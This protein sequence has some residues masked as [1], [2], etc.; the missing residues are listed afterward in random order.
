[1]A[2]GQNVPDM[3]ALQ[4]GLLHVMLNSHEAKWYIC[5]HARTRLLQTGCITRHMAKLQGGRSQDLFLPEPEAAQVYKLLGSCIGYEA[6][7][8]RSPQKLANR[9]AYWHIC[10]I[11]DLT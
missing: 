2:E 6:I 10:R 1:M 4:A 11:T 3:R 9:Y 5:M 8:L 7:G